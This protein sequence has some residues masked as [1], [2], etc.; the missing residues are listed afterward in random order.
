[1][2]KS[3][4]AVTNFRLRAASIVINLWVVVG[5]AGWERQKRQ[6]FVIMR[7][8]EFKIAVDIDIS[9]LMLGDQPQSRKIV[10]IS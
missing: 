3:C 10:D 7:S 5:R 9:N 4:M 1:L 8:F 6:H 2:E